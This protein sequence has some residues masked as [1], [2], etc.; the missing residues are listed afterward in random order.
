VNVIVVVS[1][2]AV[3]LLIGCHRNTSSQEQSAPSASVI[4][5]G[6]AIGTCDNIEVCE[7]ECDAGSAD[8]CRRLGATYALGR[9]ASQ[10]ESR[11]A[12]LYERACAMSDPSACLFAGQMNEFARGV[13]K[14]DA[15]AARFYER[16]CELQWAAGCYNLAIMYERGTGVRPDRARA[17]ELYQKACTAGAK[18]SCEKANEMRARPAGPF[19][20]GGL[21]W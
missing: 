1:A 15:K 14:D 8:R 2:L 17:G 3:A 19:F 20:E 11:A 9:G 16:S 18:S 5:L 12:T 6:L 13:V 7:T 4:T 10:D 21:P